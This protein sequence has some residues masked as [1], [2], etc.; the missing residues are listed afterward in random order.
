MAD[1]QAASL[2]GAA[3][4]LNAHDAQKYA[5]LFT[6]DGVQRSPGQPDAT[7]KDAIASRIQ[8]FFTAFPDLKFAISRVWMKGNVVVA[9]W[10]WTGTDTGGFMGKKPTGRAVGLEGVSVGSY[11]DDGLV[12]ELHLYNDDATLMS[13]LDP[14]AKKGSFRSPPTL[15]AS[16]ETNAS[17]GSADEDKL[18]ASVKG[19]YSAI[20]DKK[21]ADVLGYFNDDT[22]MED[23]SMPASMKGL[24]DAKAMYKAYTTAFPDLKQTLTNQ[25]AVKDFVITEG[26][27]NGTHKG[28]VGP[29]R[30][31]GKPVSIHFVDVVQM[32]DAKVARFWTW[33]NGVEFLMEVGAIKPPSAPA[34]GAPAGAPSPKK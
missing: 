10:G 12:K 14:K 13:Q 6:A 26:V 11:S 24:K 15:A 25:W 1:L 7:G 20:D 23:Y 19:L 27:L 22:T 28:P 29:V 5:A 32:K 31:T 2:K 16:T 9:E 21:Q 18:I 33:S 34:S 4:A 30:A 17:T 8:Q 3:D